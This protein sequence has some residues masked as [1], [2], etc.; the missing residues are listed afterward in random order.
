MESLNLK[1]LL[2][3]CFL[4]LILAL[5]EELL[6]FIPGFQLTFLLLMIYSELLSFK[7]TALI[8][9][10]YLVLD[11]FWMGSLNPFFFMSLY[12][13]WTIIPLSTK[14]IFK[15]KESLM[16]SLAQSVL[17]A[18]SYCWLLALASA[19]IYQVDLKTYLKADIAYELALVVSNC[20]TVLWLYRPIKATLKKHLKY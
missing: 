5:Q 6:A 14:T 9:F 16:A 12:L 1:R 19:F 8:I 2:R 10:I 17:C 7:S 13:A 4:A 11:S 15:R 3:N 20:L 18:F